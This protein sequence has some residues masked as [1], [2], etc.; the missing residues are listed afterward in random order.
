MARS[1]STSG[2]AAAQVA[3]VDPGGTKP[4]KSELT[5]SRILQAA[6]TVLAQHPYSEASF[7]MIAKE[8]GFDHP[9]INY[10]FP[11]KSD[12]FE[13]VVVEICEDFYHANISCLEG[14]RGMTPREGFSLYIDRFLEFNLEN[15]EPL[16]II[17]LNIAQVDRLEEVPGYRHIPDMLAR[18]RS[19]F[20]ESVPLRASPEEVGMFL[21]SYNALVIL[22]LGA[23]S[24][25]AQILGLEPGSAAYLAWVKQTLLYIF[26]PLLEG[27]IAGE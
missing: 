2:S 11:Y 5:R 14:L 4:V 22:L 19:T 6:R 18:T 25:Q 21:G 7:R 26:L 24:C 16:R 8:G 13:A 27:L 9:L 3:G 1:T 23:D 12:L 15:P 17:M 10:Y 20:E